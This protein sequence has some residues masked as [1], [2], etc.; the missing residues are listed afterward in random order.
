MVSGSFYWGTAC[1]AAKPLF[2]LPLGVSSHVSV[3]PPV[4]LIGYQPPS[5]S[6]PTLA[7][8][9]APVQGLFKGQQV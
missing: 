8:D 9:A 2:Q 4:L 1:T 5:L 7:P 6:L 3:A